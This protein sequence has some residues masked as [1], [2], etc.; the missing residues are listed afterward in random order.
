M[1][2]QKVLYMIKKVLILSLI[3]FSTIGIQAAK[4][5]VSV[6]ATTS[7]NTSI[8]LQRTPMNLP[9]EVIFDDEAL[10]VEVSCATDLEGEVYLYNPSEELIDQSPCLNT[11]LSISNADYHTLLIEGDGWSASA[12]IE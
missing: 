1:L 8:K 3:V 4:K 11:I 12:V 5:K 2:H 10:T 9:I 7:K 6:K